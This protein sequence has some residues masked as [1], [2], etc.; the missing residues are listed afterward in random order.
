LSALDEVLPTYRFRERHQRTIAAPPERVWSALLAFTAQEVP[1]SR[2][3]MGIRGLPARISGRPGGLGRGSHRAIIEEFLKGGFR[4]LRVDP[5]HVLVAGAAMQPWRLVQGEVA[6]VRDL[7]GFRAFKRP[8][9]VVAAVSF[10]LEPIDKGTRLSTETRVQPTDAG[11][12]RAFLPYW[13]VIRAGSGL[14]R[15][16]MLRAVARRAIS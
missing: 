12:G 8:G 5:P 6:D 7:A 2:L 4:E 10:E 15:R 13:L 9:F 11:A 3:L 14:I 16:E 1:L